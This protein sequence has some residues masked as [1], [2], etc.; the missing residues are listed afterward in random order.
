[1]MSPFSGLVDGCASEAGSFG[2]E[3]G[4]ADVFADVGFETFGDF[5]LTGDTRIL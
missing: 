1:M 5:R 3:V 4:E 2:L